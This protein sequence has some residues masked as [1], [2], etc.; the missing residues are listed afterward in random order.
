VLG[1]GH[2]GLGDLLHQA[3]GHHCLGS[4][5]GFLGW[6]EERDMGAGTGV[7]VF[8]EQARCA[9]EGSDVHVVAAGMHHA[10]DGG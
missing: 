3:V 8:G 5:G 1:Q 6:L 7:F 9:Q 2:H 4:C 10:F